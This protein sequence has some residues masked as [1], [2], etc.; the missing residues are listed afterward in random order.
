MQPQFHK[1]DLWHLC[2]ATTWL[3]KYL[4][5]KKK[6]TSA[7]FLDQILSA[8][9]KEDALSVNIYNL[10][11]IAGLMQGVAHSEKVDGARMKITPEGETESSLTTIPVFKHTIVHVID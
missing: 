11:L 4:K 10:K 6:K 7:V 9:Y 2:K 3:E 1:I 8:R 5:K